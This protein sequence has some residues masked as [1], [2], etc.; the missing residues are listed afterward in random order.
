MQD[1]IVIED[2]LDESSFNHKKILTAAATNSETDKLLA[3]W[4]SY[5]IS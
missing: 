1:R 4:L 2:D 5:K 3:T